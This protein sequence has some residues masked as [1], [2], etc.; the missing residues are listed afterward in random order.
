LPLLAD[1]PGAAIMFTTAGP[2][3]ED[4]GGRFALAL[5]KA[6]LAALG[7]SVGPQASARGVRLRSVALEAQ[8]VPKGPLNPET[9]ADHFWQSFTAP[10]GSVFRLAARDP[11]AERDQLPLD[12]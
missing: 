9:V 11:A 8:V 2:R 4:A 10:R 5:G 1:R 7:A 6:C 12:V 3:T